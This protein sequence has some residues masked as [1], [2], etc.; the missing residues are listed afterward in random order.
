MVDTLAPKK[1][2]TQRELDTKLTPIG[3]QV[4]RAR[5]RPRLLDTTPVMGTET[6]LLDK[7]AQAEETK[8]ESMMAPTAEQKQT[9]K[10]SEEVTD[11]KQTGERVKEEDPQGLVMRP[12]DY[13]AKG[14]NNKQVSGPILVGEKGPEMIVPTGNG[15]ISILPNNVVS[16]MMTKPMKKAQEGMDDVN[17]GIPELDFARP[18]ES[19]QMY[20]DSIN[21][22]F[23]SDIAPNLNEDANV[24]RLKD[25]YRHQFASGLGT[26]R[27]GKNIT[28][29]AGYGNEVRNIALGSRDFEENK[30][31]IKNNAVGRDIAT[32]FQKDNPDLKD[33]DLEDKFTSFFDKQFLDSV[34]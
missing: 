31:D 21:K 10:S 25:N 8:V 4:V 26:I 23:D 20:R 16:G 13:A 34:N 3:E 15:K 17:I 9:V 11:V 33:K 14:Y 24:E 28:A 5:T 22:K 7:Q 30:V 27:Y 6:S 1:I 19:L 29:I 18:I 32:K 12:L 2:F